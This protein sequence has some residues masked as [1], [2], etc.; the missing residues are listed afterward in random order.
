M[1]QI[2]QFFIMESTDLGQLGGVV[3]NSRMVCFYILPGPFQMEIAC[4]SHVCFGSLLLLFLT[5]QRH[6]S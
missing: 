4:S 6:A 5:V 1:H 2:P 3:A